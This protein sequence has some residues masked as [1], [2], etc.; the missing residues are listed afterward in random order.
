MELLWQ[1][2]TRFIF[3][4]LQNNNDEIWKKKRRYFRGWSYFCENFEGGKKIWKCHFWTELRTHSNDPIHPPRWQYEIA[5]DHVN[6]WRHD[7]HPSPPP[8]SPLPAGEQKIQRRGSPFL[9]LSLSLSPPSIPFLPLWSSPAFRDS[10]YL[11]KKKKQQ[12]KKKKK[13]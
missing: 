7:R 2:L 6:S 12:Q 9:S 1:I 11:K 5:G 13:K 10:N 8:V 4:N 3:E